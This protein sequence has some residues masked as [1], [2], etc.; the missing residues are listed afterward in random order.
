MIFSLYVVWKERIYTS[1]G[2]SKLSFSPL[3]KV[4]RLFLLLEYVVG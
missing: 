2:K 1:I 4:N 3:V